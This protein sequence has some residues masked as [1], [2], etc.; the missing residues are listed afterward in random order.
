M[1]KAFF[2]LT[3][4]PFGMAPDAEF[5]FLTGKHREAVAGLT[6]AITSRKGF[7]VLSG[8]VGTGKTTVLNWALSRLSGT[9]VATSVIL[10]PVL[11][12]NEFL[13]TVM[14]GFGMQEIPDSRPRRFRKLEDFLCGVAARGGAAALV[15]DE[16]HK[17][18]PELLEEIR[19]MGNY[20]RNG[21]K[22]LQILLIGQSEIDDLLNRHDLRQLKQRI[23]VRLTVEPLDRAELDRYIQYRW[24]KAGGQEPPFPPEVVSRIF[25]WS[26]GIPR[27]VNS[28]SDNAL[29]LAFADNLK[30]LEVEH[31]D[32]VAQDLQLMP[33]ARTA[34]QS[35][36]VRVD[37][38]AAPELSRAA[39]ELSRE[40]AREATREVA[41][42]AAS[43]VPPVKLV[44]LERYHEESEKAAP[45]LIRWA[46]KLG[47]A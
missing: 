9:K 26:G 5:L 21:E 41:R 8:Q 22:L 10:N 29:M 28:L 6:Y 37:K 30:C 35:A 40:V 16:A 46:A 45:L 39:S 44:T 33:P 32:S 13:E 7:L 27:L 3:R 20:E 2:G 42:E 38:P 14:L 47:L 1:Y 11:T 34:I 43:F 4:N 18:T 25:Y 19:L 36:P 12:S 17:L 31:I 15:V 23:C 24:K